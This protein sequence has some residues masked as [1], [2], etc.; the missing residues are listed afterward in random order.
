MVSH[1]NFMRRIEA[2]DHGTMT[3]SDR[4]EKMHKICC[5]YRIAIEEDTGKPYRGIL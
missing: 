2:L 5:D 3:L 4:N 1:K